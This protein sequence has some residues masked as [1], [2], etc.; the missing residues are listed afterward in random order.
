MEGSGV[1]D[2][3]EASC[4]GS[5]ETPPSEGSGESF[6]LQ[7]SLEWN[8]APLQTQNLPLGLPILALAVLTLVASGALVLWWKR[9][10]QHW[11]LVWEQQGPEPL[12]EDGLPLLPIRGHL[13]LIGI[14]YLV[15]LLTLWTSGTTAAPL[16]TPEGTVQLCPIRTGFTLWNL[17]ETQWCEPI[18]LD[19]QDP[20]SQS[21]VYQLYNSVQIDVKAN[22]TLCSCIRHHI[23]TYHDMLR[24]QQLYRQ[25]DQVVPVTEVH[26]Q[27]MLNQH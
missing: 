6:S 19:D 10:N 17:D 13:P 1:D 25:W 21:R 22:A 2:S 5:G 27:E 11:E 18:D 9:R 20:K 12:Q 7:D 4:E 3:G 16:P 14:L 8:A 24:R 15:L 23:S 26:C